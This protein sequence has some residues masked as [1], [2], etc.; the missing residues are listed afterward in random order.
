MTESINAPFAGKVLTTLSQDGQRI[1]MRPKRSEGRFLNR[2][3]AVGYSL[4]VLF[5]ILPFVYI[6]GHPA[7]L[8]D[9][10]ARRFHLFGAT[11]HP[12][13]SALLML[14]MLSVFLGIFWIT[15]VFGRVWCGWG[16]PQTV[17]ME[18]LF[19]PIEN[20]FE[21]GPG[22]QRRL[23]AHR[24]FLPPWPRLLKYVVFLV[25]AFV[26][27]NQFLA[28]F[29]GW[30]RLATWVTASPLDNP[31]GFAVMAFTTGLVFFDFA[32][33]REQMCTVACPYARLQSALLDRHSL[34]VGYDA[35]R[36][37]ARRR[38]KARTEGDGSGD[39]V[40]CGACVATC[41][42]G[43]DIRDGLQLE[44]IACTQCIDA[45]DHVME[46]LK[47]PRGLIRLSSQEALE[48]R[49]RSKILRPRALA[50]PA[51]IAALLGIMGFVIQT[52]GDADV[53]VLR[54]LNAPYVLEAGMVRNQLRVKV[55]NRADGDRTYTMSIPGIDPASILAPQF[56]LRVRKSDSMTTPV[57]VTLPKAR[58]QAG[59]VPVKVHVRDG[60]GFEVDVP[61]LLLGPE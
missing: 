32:Y 60:Q 24:G 13:D 47:K 28:Y 33:F 1:W 58:F 61:F 30:E 57:F 26:L 29:V 18:L 5:L 59:Q 46:K 7:I 51:I 3:R 48:T 35:L 20:F 10:T 52:K 50:Y 4:I 44:C 37:E 36:G 2:R 16:C 11:F 43:I 27:G 40:D 8:L 42:T 53:T 31:G 55:V 15:A 39:C 54:Q 38:V 22:K 34:I 23:D 41:P 49:A 19:R 45:C 56:P 6:G 12:T 25:V 17:Y 21:G 9:V 14:L